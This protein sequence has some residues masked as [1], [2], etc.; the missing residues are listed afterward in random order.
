MKSRQSTSAVFVLS[1][2]AAICLAGSGDVPA[3]ALETRLTIPISGTVDGGP[4][5]VSLSGSLRIVSTV[6]SDVA[7][8]SPK[9]RHTITLDGVSGIGLTSG[10]RYVATGEDRLLRPLSVSDHIDVMFPFYRA[11]DGARAARTAAAAITLTFDLPAQ[12]LTGA[13]ATFGA[14]KLPAR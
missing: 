6:V 11:S 13:T 9:V 5:S 10:A 1:C 4:E 3:A 2:V 8:V 12:S 7:L 14:P